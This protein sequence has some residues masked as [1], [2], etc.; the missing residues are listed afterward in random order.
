MTSAITVARIAEAAAIRLGHGWSTD[1]STWGSTAEF[2][3]PH[4]VGFSLIEDYEGDLVLEYDRQRF[5]DSIELP[6]GVEAFDGGVYLP[7]ATPADG[8]DALAQRCADAIRAI[9]HH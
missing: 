9:T 8:L 7:L 6:E 4:D 5:P 2:I 1:P 3:G